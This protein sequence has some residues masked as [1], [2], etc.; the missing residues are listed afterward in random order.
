VRLGRNLGLHDGHFP[1]C[2]SNITHSEF[3]NGLAIAAAHAR[4]LDEKAVGVASLER[5][6]KAAQN[7][8]IAAEELNRHHNLLSLSE[9]TITEFRQ[10]PF[11]QPK[12]LQLPHPPIMNA[13]VPAL[14]R[15][16]PPSAPTWPSSPFT[17]TTSPTA[18]RS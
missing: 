3:E 8:L 6:R 18:K 15:A 2:A 12:P 13:A 16:L 10:R 14:A 17:R 1:L 7:S 11:H 4:Q 9:A 5:T